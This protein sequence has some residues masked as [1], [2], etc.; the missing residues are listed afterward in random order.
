VDQLF[1]S[2]EKRLARVL[3]LLA[4]FGKEGATEPM[5]PKISQ[6]V[7]SWSAE[8]QSRFSISLWLPDIANGGSPLVTATRRSAR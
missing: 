7:R 4:R 5:I 3:V 2:S 6:E 1:N 8:S